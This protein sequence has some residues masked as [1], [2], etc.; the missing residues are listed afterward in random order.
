M[1][2]ELS[3]LRCR[4]NPKALLCLGARR[5]RPR[6]AAFFPPPPPPPS[7]LKHTD[8]RRNLSTTPN[9]A[10]MSPEVGCRSSLLLALRPTNA[11][12]HR[13]RLA[14]PPRTVLPVPCLSSYLHLNAI[15]LR[16]TTFN[17][18][19]LSFCFFLLFPRAIYHFNGTPWNITLR[20]VFKLINCIRKTSDGVFNGKWS[21]S[22][23]IFSLAA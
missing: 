23:Y 1:E 19:L 9:G 13:A 12:S 15:P 20:H 5:H 11:P 7:T 3:A 14:L 21:F 10:L 4:C 17:P 6:G 2:W 18:S 22:R 16:C 8:Q